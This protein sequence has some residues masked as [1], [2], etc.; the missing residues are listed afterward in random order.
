M[1]ALELLYLME[2]L[3]ASGFDLTRQDMYTLSGFDDPE[4][5]KQEWYL[6]HEDWREEAL[7]AGERNR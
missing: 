6:D 5:A 7:T 2:D 4:A 1:T 3:E